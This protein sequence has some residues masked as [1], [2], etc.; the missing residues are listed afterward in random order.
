MMIK[1]A[2]SNGEEFYVDPRV[3]SCITKNKRHVGNPT[4]YVFL[5]L[6]GLTHVEMNGTVE[7]VKHKIDIAIKRNAE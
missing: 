6:P 2:E 1:L 7:E 5:N 3:I 4:C